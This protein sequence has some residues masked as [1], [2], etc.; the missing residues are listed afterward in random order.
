MR[1]RSAMLHKQVKYVFASELVYQARGNVG[2]EEGDMVTGVRPVTTPRRGSPEKSRGPDEWYRDLGK[3]MDVV[4]KLICVA[5]V[6]FSLTL[7]CIDEPPLAATAVERE[8]VPKA[9]ND[10]AFDLYPKLV[11]GNENL[12]FS[13][14]SISAALAMTFAGARAGTESQMAKVLHF[15]RQGQ[16]IHSFFGSF[17]RTLTGS[18]LNG[19]GL[20]IA[21]A[22]W[23]QKTYPFLD[24]FV[25]PVTDNYGGG[26]R[27]IDFKG[28]PEKARHEINMWVENQTQEKI[29]DLIRPGIV[30]RFTRLILTN[31][32]YFKGM[33]SARF[34]KHRT[35]E[36][37]FSLADGA[38]TRVPMM[39]LTDRFSYLKGAGFQV[40]ELPYKGGALSMIVLLPDKSRGIEEFERS[41]TNEKLTEWLG[42]LRRQEVAVYLPRFKITTPTYRLDSALKSLGMT[43]AFSPSADFSGMTS[44]KDLYISAV[45]HKGYV[46]VNEE[47]TEAA[48]ATAVVMRMKGGGPGSIPEFKADHPFMFLIRHNRSNCILFLGRFCKP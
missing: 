19:G 43:D 39:R 22:L 40:L 37:A 35:K 20:K 6:L 7:A 44:N 47:G 3:G 32:I 8:G 10:L 45:L 13:P 12:F 29:K 28:S 42:R 27:L 1:F 16:G 11:R 26:L 18:E 21:N 15:A 31:A 17:T 38:E 23:G 5:L 9:I 14:Y 41:V 48:A 2:G 36:A 46:D 4:R 25:K 24:G 33:W 34:E 30:D